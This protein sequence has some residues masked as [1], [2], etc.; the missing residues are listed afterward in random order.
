M[1]V[2]KARGCLQVSLVEGVRI[3]HDYN[4]YNC[5]W[6]IGRLVK[7]DWINCPPALGLGMQCSMRRRLPAIIELVFSSAD[8]EAKRDD[9]AQAKSEE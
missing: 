7:L 9:D 2:W 1:L 6:L 8:D 4:Y 5:S 3:D